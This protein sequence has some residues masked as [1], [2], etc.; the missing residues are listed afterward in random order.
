M[1][2]YKTCDI[3]CKRIDDE[4]LRVEDGTYCTSA[5]CMKKI[6]RRD[7]CLLTRIIAEFGQEEVEDAFLDGLK[8]EKQWL[9]AQC[10]EEGWIEDE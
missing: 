3:C 8:E 1:S 6:L 10:L 2:E 4:V 9:L 7:G 5:Y